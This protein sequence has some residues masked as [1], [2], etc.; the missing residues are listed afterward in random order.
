MLVTE[1]AGRLRLVRQ[2]QLVPD[3]VPGVPA[4]RV[5]GQGGL[6]DV[7][8]HPK[9]SENRLIYLSY[10]KASARREAQHHRGRQGTLRPGSTHE[11]GAGD[12]GAGLVRR[13]GT[14]RITAGLRRQ[15]LPVC[16]HRRPPGVPVG[17][18]QGASGAG[19]RHSPRQ[20]AAS[21][22][23]WTGAA[24]QPVRRDARARCPRS[25]ATA[26]A[27]SRAWSFDAATSELWLTEH[28][29]Q[30][31]DELNRVQAG[32][33]Y[34]WPV[35]GFGVMYRTGAAIHAGTMGEG[36]EPPVHVWVPS[37]APSGLVRY[38]GDQF[39]G[40]KGSLLAGAL[41]GE[42]LVR[43]D[44][45]RTGASSTA[46]SCCSARDVFATCAGTGR[47]SLRGLR[48]PHGGDDAHRPAR[49]GRALRP[50]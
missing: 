35:V 5:G 47:P 21:P 17:G 2:G 42:Q 14:L 46:N 11:C 49:A 33:N 39:P 10:S 48:E 9:F 26:I 34:G 28:G 16:H 45:R 32:R 37:V 12:R 40:W 7:V 23:R 8:A 41:G 20:G 44:A 18:S 29:P 38:S 31:G 27:T 15:G 19:S 4:V 50:C 6:L 30:G 25:G 43:L 24:G 3:P 36:M 1:R 13:R 22:R